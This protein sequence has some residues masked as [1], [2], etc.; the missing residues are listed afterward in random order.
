[1]KGLPGSPIFRHI[2]DHHASV[3]RPDRYD[4]HASMKLMGE[5]VKMAGLE[6]FIGAPKDFPDDRP[7][8]DAY[9]RAGRGNPP[10]S[11][12]VHH[13]FDSVASALAAAPQEGSWYHALLQRHG[14]VGPA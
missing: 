13:W 5:A 7:P 11:R 9:F 4:W 3:F 10:S 8:Y 2:L 1:M 12:H 14:L 6:A